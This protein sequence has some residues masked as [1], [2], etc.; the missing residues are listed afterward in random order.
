[1]STTKLAGAR[2]ESPAPTPRFRS[3]NARTVR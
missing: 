1:V 3:T 2:A